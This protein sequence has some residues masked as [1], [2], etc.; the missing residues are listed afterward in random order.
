MEWTHINRKIAEKCIIL[1]KIPAPKE[2]PGW[3]GAS[4]FNFFGRSVSRGQPDSNLKEPK[5]ENKFK[6]KGLDLKIVHIQKN[7]FKKK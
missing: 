3:A 1:K 6:L 4:S 7:I 5:F 2:D